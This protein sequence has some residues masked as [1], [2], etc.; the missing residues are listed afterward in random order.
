MSVGMGTALFTT[1]AGL[2]AAIFL[3]M[4]YMVLGRQTEH[5]I[6]SWILIYD[7]R[8]LSLS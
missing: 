1:L 3:S 6:A 5:V 7:T 8:R 4:Q 2:V